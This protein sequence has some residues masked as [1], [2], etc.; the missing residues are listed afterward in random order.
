MSEFRFKSPLYQTVELIVLIFLV[1]ASTPF[2]S[3]RSILSI[4]KMKATKWYI[5]NGLIMLAT[6]FI[7][8]IVML[9][10]VMYWYAEVINTSYWTAIAKLPLGCKISI[11][12][13]FLPQFYWFY[14]MLKG[15]TKVSSSNYF[16]A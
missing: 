1:E 3:F 5:V 14:L 10:T 7:F 15:A 12:A 4:L 8:R 16:Y 2:V 6:F 13:M 9:P 11:L